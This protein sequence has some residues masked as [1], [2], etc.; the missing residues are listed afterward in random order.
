MKE[1]RVELKNN[2]YSIYIEHGLLGH[3]EDYIK[4]IYNHNKIF[5]ITDE[6]VGHFYLKQV[7]EALKNFE[8]HAITIEGY[9]KDKCINTYSYLA[10]KLVL[11]GIRR[12]HLLIALGGGVIGDLTG[13]LAATI[14]R[15]VSYIQIPTSLL[16]QNDSSIGGKTGIDIKEGKNLIGAFYQP[17][18]VLIDP[19]TLNTLPKKEYANGLS[20]VI[21]HGI[22]GNKKI[23]EGLAKNNYRLDDDILK[24]SIEVKRKL[25]L[26]DEF[27]KGNRML[28]NFGHTF[29][30][31]IEKKYNYEKYTHGEAISFGILMALHLGERLGITK[32]GIYDQIKNLFTNVGLP[33]TLLDEKEYIDLI[34]SD[35]KNI[36]G[37]LNFILVSDYEKP[38][39]LKLNENKLNEVM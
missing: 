32:E 38:F 11:E 19:E 22:I 35:K 20:E 27:D 13:F 10:S 2:P 39:V 34:R 29:G 30:H 9:E 18:M 24:M 37:T 3:L 21:K 31:A 23:L 1:I 12:E 14:Y 4:K 5:I 15:G 17:K 33:N 8:V 16:A 6:R 7:K 28:L 36:A 26:E 25:V